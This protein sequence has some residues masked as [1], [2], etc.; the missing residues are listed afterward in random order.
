MLTTGTTNRITRLLVFMALLFG[1]AGSIGNT[2]AGPFDKSA[3]DSTDGRSAIR[4]GIELERSR[5]W[6]QAIEFYQKAQKLYPA[7]KEIRYGLRRSKIH[8]GIARR[9][10]DRSF[11]TKLLTK[12]R[13]DA[14]MLFDS[15]LFQIRTQYVEPISST[16]F[17][18]HGTESLYLALGNP[19][20]AKKNLQNIPA[21]RIKKLRKILRDEFWNLP[22]A[23]RREAMKTV[24]QVCDIARKTAG[25]SPS[26]VIME[27]IF[28][29]CNA[30]DDYSSVLTPDRLDDLYGNIDGE[31]VG[32]GIEMKAKLGKG[33]LLANILPDSPAE[34]GGL[35]KNEYIVAINGIDCRNMTTD[36]AARLLRG[37]AGST[38]RLQIQ[39]ANSE[40][41]RNGIFVR[42]AVQVKS[43][44]LATMVDRQ[45]GIGYIRMTGF[46]KTTAME[47][48]AALT[49]LHRQGMR[50]LIWDVRGNPG[51]LLTSAVEVLD[52][53]I[54]EGILV[55]TRG[56]TRDQNE[57]HH[58]NRIGTWGIPLVLLV[59]EDSAS[60]SEI[61]AGA[62]R[63]HRR[64]TI[65]GRKT[66]GKWSVQTIFP[67]RSG[68]G[69]RLT[70]A[71]FYSPKGLTHGK[72]GVRPDILVEE[73]S[74]IVSRYRGPLTPRE[75]TSDRDLH[76]GIQILRNQLTQK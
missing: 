29:G 71:K 1:F 38:V 33:M 24:S 68:T 26:A 36:E 51:G 42:K 56:R 59:D 61:V 30:L 40:K 13:N 57:S 66:F 64:G 37:R 19:K 31:F 6:I 44:P 75:I 4:T 28:G 3:M 45:A 53:F 47:L 52:R 5:N 32:L 65:V 63:D 55:S 50:S 41:I 11:E 9:Y 35:R 43:I 54:D 14:L 69:L 74:Q 39:A 46:Q 10:A 8:F 25:L 17:V 15:L 70:T 12:S 16:S 62:I 20:F 34:V 76:R 49:K 72:V 18:A 23:N 73:R 27:Y 67:V 60:A 21:E 48:D 58:A 7:S 22:V 2:V